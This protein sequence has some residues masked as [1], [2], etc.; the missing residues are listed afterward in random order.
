[1]GDPNASRADVA[2]LFG[3][4]AFGATSTDLDLHTNRPYVDVV[5]FLLT[6]PDPALRPPA[7]DDVTRLQ[8]ES[9]GTAATAAQWWLERMRTTTYPL[10]ERLTL[11]WHDHWATAI[12]ES[13]AVPGVMKQNQTLRIHSLGSFRTMCQALTI[14]P[15]MLQWLDGERSTKNKPNENYAR[16][17]F[18]LFT[19]GVFPQ[20]YTETDIRE[21]ARAF[22]G[23]VVDPTTGAA[24]FEPSRHDTGTKTILGQTVTNLGAEEYKA[25]IEIALSQPIASRFVAYK[26]VQNLAYVPT[27][28]DLLAD[29]DPLVEEIAAA[30]R[31]NDWQLRPAIRTM[32]LSDNFRSASAAAGRQVV[33]Q[34]VELCVHATKATRLGANNGTL[35]SYLTRAGQTLLRPP[36]V[37]G[38]PVGKAWLSPSTTT[39]RYDL[40]VQ[41]ANLHNQRAEQ[42]RSLFLPATADIDTGGAAWAAFM[43]LHAFTSNTLATLRSYLASR[44]G[45]GGVTEFE[46]QAGVFVLAATSPDWQV[47]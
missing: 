24:R 11:F 3:R 16:E 19:L 20:T 43:G 40:A 1:M 27:S 37:G 22:T 29:P 15:A 10:E 12:G 46:L 5:D 38:W 18:E 13:P 45:R 8:Q 28:L 14:D 47:M 21:A 41:V 4:A 39:A 25:V 17:F 32:L 35:Y 31:A 42:V 7:A 26:L 34:P 33:R 30:L 44:R 2:R 23:W 6:V 36:N 9:S